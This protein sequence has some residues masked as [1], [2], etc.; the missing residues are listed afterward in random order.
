[1]G[2]KEEDVVVCGCAENIPQAMKAIKRLKPDIV[3]V[4]I[5]LEDASGLELISGERG[6]PLEKKTN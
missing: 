3:T 6:P 5:S 2:Y 4:D 1:L